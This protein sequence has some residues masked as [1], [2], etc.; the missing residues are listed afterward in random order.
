MFSRSIELIH[1]PSG[2]DHILGAVGDLQITVLV[3]APD[4]SGGKQP[5][6]VSGLE[7]SLL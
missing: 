7:P 6:A 4:V 1:S 5:S 3:D 2:L